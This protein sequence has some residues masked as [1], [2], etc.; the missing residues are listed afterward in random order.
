M[1]KHIVIWVLMGLLAESWAVVAEST[2]PKI[3]VAPKT[4]IEAYAF[5]LHDVRLLDGPFRAA[6]ERDA[7]YL[8]TLEPDHLL[9]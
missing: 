6:M 7:I 2:Q 8:L 5:N 3:K 4:P 9:A 1:K